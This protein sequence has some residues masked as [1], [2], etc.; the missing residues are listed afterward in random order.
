MTI[1]KI[2]RKKY[3][4]IR[5]HRYKSKYVKGRIDREKLINLAVNV[6]AL[7]LIGILSVFIYNSLTDKRVSLRQNAD[8]VAAMRISYSD[9]RGLGRLST[10][11]GMD[12]A[13]VLA[14]YFAEN[15]FFR[16]MPTVNS[17]EY[18]SSEFLD[19]FRKIG[20]VYRR[21]D[22]EPLEDMFRVLLNEIKYFPIPESFQGQILDDYTFGDTWGAKRDYGGDRTHL[23]TDIIDTRNIRGRI[24]I[25]S[26]T[27]GRIMHIGWNELG[28]FRIGIV[29]ESG[30]YYYYAHFA[31]FA[32]NLDVGSEVSAGEFLG[33]M[34]DTGYSQ[35]EGTTGNFIVHLHIGIAYNAPFVDDVFWLNPYILLRNIEQGKI[36]LN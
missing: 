30:T 1:K 3:A 31:E 5:K 20:S 24:P 22:I 18:L 19:G 29:S 28:G 4:P 34:G 10:Q 21:S 35:I 14:Y 13:Q 9:F 26:M 15:N 23:G 16:G 7:I 33:F 8:Y 32:P 2:R 27:E 25:V 17:E 36:I 6:T 12:F 11:R